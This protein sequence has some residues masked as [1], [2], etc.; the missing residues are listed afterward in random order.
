MRPIRC[1]E[2]FLR[3]QKSANKIFRAEYACIELY[4]QHWKRGRYINM[5]NF[6][7]PTAMPRSCQDL[8]AL[9][10]RQ[11]RQFF[12]VD[13]RTILNGSGKHIIIMMF[14][15]CSLFWQ[16]Q[17]ADS[18]ATQ[19]WCTH[20]DPRPDYNSAFH[21]ERLTSVC[22]YPMT[23]SIYDYSTSQPKQRARRLWDRGVRAVCCA[24]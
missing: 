22:S 5:G 12:W 15:R 6:F 3:F 23:T 21:G 8:P 13:S 17:Y 1:L 16:D 19:N 7:C 10:S 2:C 4:R 14:C 18:P 11:W 20:I 9:P 24:L